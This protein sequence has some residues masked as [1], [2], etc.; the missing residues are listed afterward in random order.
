MKN[1]TFLPIITVLGTVLLLGILAGCAVVDDKDSLRMVQTQ[2]EEPASDELIGQETVSVQTS[3][4]AEMIQKELEKP[5]PMALS[6]TV[7]EKQSLDTPHAD[8][9]EEKLEPMTISQMM[10]EK[11]TPVELFSFS[12]KGADIRDVLL[13]ISKESKV[14]IIVD[15]EIKGEVTVDLKDV[16]LEQALNQ[17]LPQ[18]GLDYK[19]EDNFVKVFKPKVEMQTKV[20][21]LNYLATKRI[22]SRTITA[23]TGAITQTGGTGAGVG[24]GIV[25]GGLAGG[26]GGAGVAGGGGAPAA[27]F[28]TLID[29]DTADIWDDIQDGLEAIIFGK[30]EYVT[31]SERLPDNRQLQTRITSRGGLIVEKAGG[32]EEK[33]VTEI[34]SEQGTEREETII[35]RAVQMLEKGDSGKRLLINKVSSTIMVTDYPVNLNKVADFLE[36]LEGSAQRQVVIRAKIVEVTLS[37]EYQ[38]GIDWE[39][40]QNEIR[41]KEFTLPLKGSHFKKS[42]GS[43]KFGE[44]ITTTT[45]TTAAVS[46]SVA[47]SD[48]IDALSKQGKIRVLSSPR[49]ATLNNQKAIIKVA[50]QDVFFSQF[51][52]AGGLTGGGAPSILPATVDIGIILDVLPQIGSDGTLTMSIHPSVSEKVGE[53]PN[54]AGGT[55]PIVDIRETDTTVKIADGQTAIIGGLMRESTDEQKKGVPGLKSIPLLGRLFSHNT[56]TKKNAE[57]VIMLTPTILVGRVVDE[58]SREERERLQL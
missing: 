52:V 4:E 9:V 39:F 55:F 57:L 22:G 6:Q 18:Y 29:S 40:V 50:R 17:L 33:R 42:R 43:F 27:S 46:T 5:A 19:R 41:L 53:V 31:K 10:G 11:R 30:P 51:G 56:I 32:E 8:E 16:T 12:A 1:K 25:G 47:F 21:T 24:G 14:N 13:A 35:S 7:E 23:S 45:G 58:L 48:V 15:P 38:M 34:V 3:A 20:F 28:S 2:S 54:P 49:V 26:V 37:D 36:A 44:E